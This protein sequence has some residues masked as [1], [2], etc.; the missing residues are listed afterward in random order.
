MTVRVTEHVDPGS[1]AFLESEGF[2]GFRSVAQLR[3]AG[4]ASRG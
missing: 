1:L 2:Q 4:L 3:S